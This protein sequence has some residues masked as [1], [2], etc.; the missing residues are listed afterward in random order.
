M[1]VS[2]GRISELRRVL[3][4]NWP[5]GRSQLDRL[6]ALGMDSYAIIPH[7]NRISSENAVRFSGVTSG[8]SLGRDGRLHRQLLWARFRRGSPKLLDTFINYTGQYQRIEGGTGTASA[9]GS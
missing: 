2:N 8:L 5:Y 6:F 4:A 1:L 3:Q 7:L 9:T